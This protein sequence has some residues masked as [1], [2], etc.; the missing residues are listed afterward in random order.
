MESIIPKE[1]PSCFKTVGSRAK[2]NF[3]AGAQKCDTSDFEGQSESF[4]H[5]IVCHV[6]SLLYI[7]VLYRDRPPPTHTRIE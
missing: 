4:I 6:Q 5:S 1:E 7:D 3:G 2:T